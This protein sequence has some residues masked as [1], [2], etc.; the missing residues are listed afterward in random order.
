MRFVSFILVATVLALSAGCGGD[1]GGGGG[2]VIPPGLC[3]DFTPSELL[4]PGNVVMRL[5][6]DSTCAVAIVEVVGTEIDE[7]FSVSAHI[8]YERTAVAFAGLSTSGSVLSR[9]GVPLIAPDDDDDVELTAGELTVGVAR[10]ADDTV[11]I[12]GTQLLM[13]LFFVP[14]NQGASDMTIQTPCLMSGE[15]PPVFLDTVTCSAGSF[16]VDP[17]N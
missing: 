8:E 4:T 7:V 17:L 10:N 9:D 11:D 1:D 6:D 5:R 13:T 3:V 16:A 12:D 14:L 15:E 2:V